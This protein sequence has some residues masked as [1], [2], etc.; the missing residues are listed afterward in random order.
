MVGVEMVRRVDP[1][2]VDLRVRQQLV[3]RIGQGLDPELTTSP[4]PELLIEVAQPHDFPE[5]ALQPGRDDAP[6]F[7]E[8]DH[9]ESEA[10][11]RCSSSAMIP[12]VVWSQTYR[13][14]S[15][16]DLVIRSR[17]PTE[18]GWGSPVRPA[19]SRASAGS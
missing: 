12:S 6:S 14:V 5:V 19:P 9:A 1:H 8:A 16:P 13:G 15:R 17:R 3:E 2:D 4:G 18:L 7:P 11:H 10:S